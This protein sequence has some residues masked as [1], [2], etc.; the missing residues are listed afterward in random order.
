MNVELSRQME[1]ISFSYDRRA[2][3]EKSGQIG[4]GK[5]TY[6]NL[7]KMVPLLVDLALT[8]RAIK[9]APQSTLHFQEILLDH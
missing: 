6:N 4:P 8:L 9:L 7:N 1:H 3:F 5:V 2:D